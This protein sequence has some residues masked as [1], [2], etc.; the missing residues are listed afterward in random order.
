MNLTIG[1]EFERRRAAA[2]VVLP[3]LRAGG[4]N[5]VEPPLLE[6]DGGE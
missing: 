1:D 5:D 2:A 6:H 3:A 4:F